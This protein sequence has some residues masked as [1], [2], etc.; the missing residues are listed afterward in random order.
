MAIQI[1]PHARD[2]FHDLATLTITHKHGVVD[3]PARMVNRYDLNAKSNIGAD[4]PLMRDSNV[5]MLQENINPKKLE[6]VMGENGFLYKVQMVEREILNRIDNRNLKLFYPSL[7]QQCKPIL[8][9]YSSGQKH[10]LIRFLCNVAK[11][12]SLESIVLPV[13]YGIDEMSANISKMG[14][15]FIPALDMSINT[16]EF[17][18]QVEQCVKIGCYDIPIIALKF[19]RYAKAN[20]AYDYIMNKFDTLHEK[21]QAVMTVGSP[22]AIYPEAYKSVSA[23]HYGAFFVADLSVESYMGGGGGSKRTI[24]MFSRDNLTT[25]KIDDGIPFD[26]DVEKSVFKN[27]HALQELFVRVATGTAD[28]EDWKGGKPKSLSRI[29]ENIRSH[30]E[31]RNLSKS[32]ESNGARDYLKAKP[33]MDTVVTRELRLNS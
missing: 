32:I 21:H 10:D 33:D 27:D 30:P 1:D 29:H 19:A 8:D 13:V 23:P 11:G 3:T 26:P 24:R 6:S 7:T 25:R 14:L 2:N 5:F 4:I 16:V 31:F 17:Q 20:Q 9:E 18:N 15:Q 12:L 28:D 22:R